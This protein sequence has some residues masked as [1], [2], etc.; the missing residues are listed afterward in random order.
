M[1]S[2]DTGTV[3]IWFV[4]G[5]LLGAAVALLLA[6]EA[7]EQTRRK[8]AFQAERGRKAFTDSSQEIVDRGRELYEK[9][10]EIAEEAAEMFERGRRVAEKKVNDSI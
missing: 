4:G 3:M 5:A 10:R 6:P 9:G 8:L 7:G 1:E 2:K